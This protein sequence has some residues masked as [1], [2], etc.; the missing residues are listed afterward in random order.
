M[1]PLDARAHNA[2]CTENVL[3][4][5]VQ[6]SGLGLTVGA[7]H[8][9]RHHNC[10]RN[11]TFRKARM[12]HTFKGI[13][14]KSGSSFDPHASAEISNVLYEEIEMDAPSQVPIW[15]GPAQEADS[16]GACSLLWPEVPF[17]SCPPPPTTMAWA[18]IT[19]RNIRIT[20]PAQ[21]PGVV[22]GN[23]QRPMQN[24][25]FENVTVTPL[26]P[27]KLPWR[28]EY[29]HCEGVVGRSIGGTAPVPPCFDRISG[30]LAIPS[31]Q[32]VSGVA[33]APPSR[34]QWALIVTVACKAVPHTV[35]IIVNLSQTC[36]Q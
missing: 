24:V 7:I 5:R 15:I 22:L 23:A 8:P 9:T 29:Y 17:A 19:L 31:S 4:E 2:K 27:R 34:E 33:A 6:A 11:V 30:P 3:I 20:T 14:I 21:S 36:Q 1:Q 28:A 12:H 10:I 18:N 25:T 13:Y 26:D 16:K 32:A 35:Q